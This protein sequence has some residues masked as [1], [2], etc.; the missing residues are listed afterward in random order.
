MAGQD[1]EDLTSRIC[2][3]RVTRG[4]QGFFVVQ[5]RLE[6]EFVEL[7]GGWAKILFQFRG[8]QVS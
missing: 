6:I 8:A 5:V 7:A 4:K 2:L 3:G 1:G